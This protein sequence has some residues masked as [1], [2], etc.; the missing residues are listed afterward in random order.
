MKNLVGEIKEFV[1]GYYDFKED[2]KQQG[3]WR[4]EMLES[5]SEDA[6]HYLE[7]ILEM[8]ENDKKAVGIR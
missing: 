6:I 8:I 5:Y 1:D 3:L 4:E 2:Q 7:T